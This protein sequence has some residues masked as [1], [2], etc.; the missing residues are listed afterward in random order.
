MYRY[1]FLLFAFVIISISCTKD[2]ENTGVALL[3]VD[4]LSIE[5]GNDTQTINLNVQLSKSV[6][7]TVTAVL[8]TVNGTAKSGEDFEG[9]SSLTVEFAPGSTTQS[10]PV[11]ILGDE[12][13]ESNEVFTIE[14]K[15][16]TNAE[17][18]RKSSEVVLKNDDTSSNQTTAGYTTPL[19]Y[20][21]RTLIW[22]DE[23]DIA[24]NITNN[25]TYEIGTGSNGWGN[26]ELQYYTANNTY[27]SDGHLNIEA[28]EESVGGRNYTS[29]RLISANSFDFKYGRVD[30]RAILPKGQGIWPALW[31][32]GSNFWNTGWPSCG[33][34][35]IMEI[36]GHQPNKLHGTIHWSN[37]GQYAS[38]GGQTTLATGDFSDQFHVFSIEW[39]DSSIT[40][41]LDD[42]P[43]H[44][45]NTTAEEMSEFR[46]NFFFIMNVAV[47]GNWPGSPNASTVF[48]QRMVVDYVRVFQ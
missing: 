15:S 26:N 36:V 37:G 34:I 10:I 30:I 22:N 13:A 43:F 9:F 31:M 45:V 6:E 14:I 12:V 4:A 23:F 33:E 27:L 8:S 32:L 20:P 48:P 5:E 25:W 17:I 1:Y 7:Q 46:E 35:D 18:G 29:A 42:E 11:Q 24:S 21:D 28:R 44:T 47:G 19:S 2:T 38:T 3:S 40:W 39:T 41:Y 16:A